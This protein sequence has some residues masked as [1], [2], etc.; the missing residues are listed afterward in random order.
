MPKQL[1]ANLWTA[2]AAEQGLAARLRTQVHL[3]PTLDGTLNTFRY[4]YHHLRCGIYCAYRSGR[5]AAFIPFVKPDYRNTWG[6]KLRLPSSVPAYYESKAKTLR[7]RKED[8]LLDVSQWWANAAIICNVPGSRLWGDSY[9][10][11]LRDLLDTAAAERDMP[12]CDFFINKRDFPNLRHNAKEPYDF[13]MD[14][15][16]APLAREHYRYYAPIVSFFTSSTTEFA[17]LPMINTDDWETAT[18]L[19][20][21]PTCN[22]IRSAAK[23]GTVTVPW[24]Q[25]IPTLL[26]R[27]SSTGAGITPQTNQRL[28]LARLSMEWAQQSRFN[29]RNPVDGVKYLDA[30]VVKLN[31]RDRKQA[32]K[33]MCHVTAKSAGV[34]F[35]D[36]IDQYKQAQYKYIAYVEGH[37]AAARYASLMAMQVVIFKVASTVPADSMWY[38]P[39]LEAWDV[40][41][42]SLEQSGD[43]LAVKADLSNLFELIDW[44]K[45]HDAAAKRI[46]DNSVAKWERFCS[47]DG[48]L[49]YM[50]VMARCIALNA[51]PVHDAQQAALKIEVEAIE[52][53]ELAGADGAGAPA[54]Y[55]RT[56]QGCSRWGQVGEDWFSPATPYLHMGGSLDARAM[57]GV[58]EYAT[59]ASTADDF[60]ALYPGL[61]KPAQGV[62]ISGK[63]AAPAPAP[64]PVAPHVPR[65]KPGARIVKPASTVE[66]R[67]FAREEQQ[68]RKSLIERLRAQR[69]AQTVLTSGTSDN[70][71]GVAAAY[72]AEA[73]AKRA[74][75]AAAASA[76]THTGSSDLFKSVQQQLGSAVLMAKP[77]A[78]QKR[79]RAEGADATSKSRSKG[80]PRR[81]REDDWEDGARPEHAASTDD[82]TA[83][84]DS[85]DESIAA[86]DAALAARQRKQKRPT[87][88]ASTPAQGYNAL[89]AAAAAAFAEDGGMADEDE[90]DAMDA[91][92]SGIGVSEDVPDMGSDMF[93]AG[94]AESLAQG[95]L[96]EYKQAP[97]VQGTRRSARAGAAHARETLANMA[98]RD[99]DGIDILGLDEAENSDSSYDVFVQD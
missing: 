6:D 43:H 31:F 79:R 95:K 26:F 96:P 16:G 12:D 3:Q 33:P 91:L 63:S 85:S 25:R 57:P 87:A 55:S 22:D 81:K 19:V 15:P 5:L 10:P 50:Q 35:A 66:A 97:A 4:M 58:L 45:R 98:T 89:A 69:Q 77:A 56:A 80:R 42:P 23:R 32:G 67:N 83:S 60:D 7:K 48:A 28:A 1:S 13:L 14:E 17:D 39:Q 52:Q 18:G 29:E 74:A 65:P 99:E 9:L 61:H 49:D 2:S 40:S 53:G 68:A 62:D 21:P 64:A 41:N 76:S 72:S 24:E 38:F 11:Q 90:D 51:K 47:R 93:M 94:F 46:A 75:A 88:A 30:G 86:V 84:G 44:A 92:L 70:A 37:S 82:D 59:A 8:V 34:R 78:G 54:W 27:G 20:Y 73:A 36:K 71:P